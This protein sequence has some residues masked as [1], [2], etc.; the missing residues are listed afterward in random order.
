MADTLSADDRLDIQDTAARYA[1]ALDTG[2]VAGLVAVFA[3][4][5]VLVSTDGVAHRGRPAIAAYVRPLVERPGFRGT[6]HQVGHHLIAGAGDRA[7]ARL[8][9]HTLIADQATG[10]HRI[11]NLGYYDDKYVRQGGVWHI[12]ERAIVH[13]RGKGIPWVGEMPSLPAAG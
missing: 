9:W 7:T 11:G 6:Q 2:D 10:A 3:P 4:D 5:G 12:A 1:W 8:Y 13:W